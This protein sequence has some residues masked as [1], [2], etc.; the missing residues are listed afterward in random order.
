MLDNL[1]VQAEVPHL[2]LLRDF[3]KPVNADIVNEM[4]W[5][6]RLMRKGLTVC[7]VSSGLGSVCTVPYNC[8]LAL[9]KGKTLLMDPEL[10]SH[11][12][13]GVHKVL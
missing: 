5:R 11:Y 6:R 4:C 10:K 13:Q 7:T 9:G 1:H 8:L 3:R 12:G 2:H